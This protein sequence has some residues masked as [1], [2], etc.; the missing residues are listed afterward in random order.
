MCQ[1]IQRLVLSTTLGA[2]WMPT[3]AWAAADDH[4]SNSAYADG[5]Q[6]GDDGGSGFAPWT[7]SF[8]GDAGAL[9]HGGPK[10]I[11][12]LPALPGNSLGPAFALST[13]ARPSFFDTSEVVRVLDTP[14][15]V[16][17]QFH[18]DVDG[19]ALDP[20][21]PGFSIGNTVQLLNSAGTERFGL[22]TNNQFLNDH[23][24]ASGNTDTG[25]AAGSSFHVAFT[26]VTPETYNLVIRPVFG[27]ATLFSQTG[28]T[29]SGP[30]GTPIDRIRISNYG[31]GSSADGSTELF[32][33]FILVAVPE[34]ASLALMS[35]SSMALIAV[36]ART[37]K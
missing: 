36:A 14:M 20:N 16:G 32:F 25:V 27:G 19:S 33:N 35:L 2:I 34:P 21:A 28:A 7:S 6:D 15:S 37:R 26:L 3:V 12:T 1:W 5:W 18:I 13:S 11:D 17:Q 10:F 24:V 9:L 4:A 31:T 29:L 8:S 22:F 23:W 30:A